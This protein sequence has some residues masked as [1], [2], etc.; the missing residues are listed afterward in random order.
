M[1]PTPYVYRAKV[2][3]VYDGDTVTVL[4]DLG[5]DIER[6]CSCRLANIDTPEIRTK[7]KDEKVAGYAARD[8][9]RELV[10]DKA[11]TLQSLTKPDKFGRLIVRI[12]L[13]DGRCLNEL[14]VQ[15]RH[16]VTYDGGTKISWAEWT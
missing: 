10:L 14:L 15:E 12:W 11:V 2:T 1:T 6:K 9:V 5:M 8:R 3:S 4:L 13:D 16:A 7:D